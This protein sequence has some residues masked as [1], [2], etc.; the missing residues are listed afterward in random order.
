MP[1]THRLQ[2]GRDGEGPAPAVVR[3]RSPAPDLLFEDQCEARVGDIRPWLDE[4]GAADPRAPLHRLT[5]F[6]TYR[7][8][9]QCP[10]C[11]TPAWTAEDLRRFP[12][13]GHAYDLGAFRTLLES[14]DGTPVRHLHATGGEATLVPELPAMVRHARDNGIPHVSIT[15]N[16]ATAWSQLEALVDGGLTEI[17]ISVDAHEPVLGD[18]LAGR[19]EA[20]RR[21]VANLERLVRL[22]AVHP[23]FFLIANT[24]ITPA[25]RAAIAHIVRF[26][27]DLGVDDIKLIASVDD[28]SALGRF[29]EATQ[30]LDEV[31][32]RLRAVEAGAFPLLRRKLLTVFSEDAVGLRTV[33]AERGDAWRCYIPLTELTA[34]RIYYY[35]CSVYLREGGT[36]LG[37]IDEPMEVR[38]ARTVRFVR[39]SRCLSDPICTRYCLRCTANFN[40]AA[41]AARVASGLSG[42]T[43]PLLLEPHSEWEAQP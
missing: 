40:V 4:P 31:H 37:R 41:N 22:R 23:S 5:L 2:E 1:V 30:L 36:P 33:A 25:N 11:R 14:L 26:L 17:R 43:A 19:A 42:E 28:T 20:W 9:L 21:A 16:G 18:Q 24:V 38:R 10:Y 7:C 13:K 32:E 8:Q 3:H 34:D 15:S 35:P 12:Q 39:E 29:S 27:M 6:A